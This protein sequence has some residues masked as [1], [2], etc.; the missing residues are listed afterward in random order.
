MGLLGRSHPEGSTA[1]EGRFVQRLKRLDRAGDLAEDVD[2]KGAVLRLRFPPS[3]IH[4]VDDLIDQGHLGT[5]ELCHTF[6]LSIRAESRPGENEGGEDPM[7]PSRLLRVRWVGD[8]ASAGL[9]DHSKR[10]TA[11]L[12]FDRSMKA[13]FKIL[14]TTGFANLVAAEPHVSAK[15]AGSA[16]DPVAPAAVRLSADDP[17]VITLEFPG[18]SLARGWC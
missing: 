13:A 1:H 7:G 12:E 17:S 6:Q 8:E 15:Q 14:K 2:V 18:G 10:V 5:R 9:F 3:S 16:P 11:V 4:L